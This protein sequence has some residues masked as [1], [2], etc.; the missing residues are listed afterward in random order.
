MSRI[1]DGHPT[2]ISFAT[3]PSGGG[4]NLTFWEKTLTP[5]GADGGGPNDTTTMRNTLY[6]TK[7]PKVLIT[8]TDMSLSVAYDANVYEDII[9]MLNDNQL[10]TITFPDSSTLAF[11]GWLDKFEPDAIVEGEQP[12][13]TITIVPSNQNASG[14]EVPPV[15]AA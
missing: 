7:S 8:L 11:W 9:D 2:T 3:T 6:R 13:A 14:V 12:V 15:Y 10:I 5:P 1:D 4:P